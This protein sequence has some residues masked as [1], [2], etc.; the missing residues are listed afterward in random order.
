MDKET[1]F[2]LQDSADE[3][4]NALKVMLESK[5]L[6]CLLEVNDKMAYDQAHEAVR[7]FED[8]LFHI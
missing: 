8:R 7:R 4:Y 1:V 2:K 5:K 6:N 3:M